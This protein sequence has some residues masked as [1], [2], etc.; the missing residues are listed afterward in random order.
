MTD[1]PQDSESRR[2]RAL[3]GRIATFV[4]QYGKQHRYNDR[5]YD[6]K[7]ECQVKRMKPEDPAELLGLA[8]SEDESA[9]SAQARGAL[10][11]GAGGRTAP[12]RE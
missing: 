4:H 2:R 12:T 1:T 11:A 9:D 3:R 10:R 7:V 8:A 6:R 5:N